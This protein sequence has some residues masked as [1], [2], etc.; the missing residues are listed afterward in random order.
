MARFTAAAAALLLL[1]GAFAGPAGAQESETGLPPVVV[2]SKFG[3]NWQVRDN[4]AGA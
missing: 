2:G 3:L 4:K 1:S